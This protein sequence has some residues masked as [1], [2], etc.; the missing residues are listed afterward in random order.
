MP[1]VQIINT[2]IVSKQ[3]NRKFLKLTVSIHTPNFTTFLRKIRLIV[4]NLLL[5]RAKNKTSNF[6]FFSKKMFFSHIKE[7]VEKARK[8][9]ILKKILKGPKI[10][11]FS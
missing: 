6:H 2:K 9:L 7:V 11:E 8:K 4:T 1:N 3:E 10:N 5:N